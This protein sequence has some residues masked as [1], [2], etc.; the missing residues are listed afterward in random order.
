LT[1][2]PTLQPG[3]KKIPWISKEEVI[4]AFSAGVTD[5]KMKEKLSMNDKLTC[6]VRLFKIADRCAKDEEGRLFMHSLSEAPLPNSKTK[7]PKH[8]EAAILVAEPN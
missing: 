4:S 8:K 3:A 2:H 1:V 7:D 5:I 6:V